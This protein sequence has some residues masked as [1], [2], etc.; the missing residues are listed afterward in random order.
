[1]AKQLPE[2][3]EADAEGHYDLRKVMEYLRVKYRFDPHDLA[4]SGN[5]FDN[6]CRRKGYKSRDPEG[7][8]RSSSQRWYAEYCADP[9]G[10]A[11][12][13]MHQSFF[14]WVHKAVCKGDKDIKRFVLNVPYYLEVH[15]IVEAPAKQLEADRINAMFKAYA[16]MVVPTEMKKFVDAQL[17]P[18]AVLSKPLRKV[19][20][21]IRDEFG[22]TPRLTRA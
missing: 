12:R 9:K 10:G 3:P 21:Y 6:W 7:V 15:D 5:H 4:R 11:T 19:L 20:Q 1:M 18:D 8:H 16:A 14:D 17:V 22:A 13:P 2:K